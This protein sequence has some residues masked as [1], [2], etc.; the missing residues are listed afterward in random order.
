MSLKVGVVTYNTVDELDIAGALRVAVS[1][2]VLGTSLVGRELGKTTVEVHGD[3]VQSAVQAAANVGDIDVEGELVA[4]SKSALEH[5]ERQD[6]GLSH[7]RAR[8]SGICSH[9]P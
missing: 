7:L 6:Q 5:L 8:S 3:E 9:F 1:G 4:W 2:T